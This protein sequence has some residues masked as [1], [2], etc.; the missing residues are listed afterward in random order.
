M[1]LTKIP[2]ECEDR[3]KCTGYFTTV[4]LRMN[5]IRPEFTVQH[6]HEVMELFTDTFD[7]F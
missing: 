5:V 6:Y 2:C 1:T 3:S 7:E 4:E